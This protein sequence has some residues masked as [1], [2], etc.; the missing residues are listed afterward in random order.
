MQSTG[1]FGIGIHS[2]F[3]VTDKVYFKTKCVGDT[4]FKDL[5]IHSS[6]NLGW[7]EY[8]ERNNAKEYPRTKSGTKCFIAFDK[9]ELSDDVFL[10]NLEYYELEDVFGV[11][12]DIIL[13]NL[14]NSFKFDMFKLIIR[15]NTE[16]R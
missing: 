5:I 2:A 4:C 7:V 15:I 1:A 12:I 13:I 16:E 6:K 10:S 11:V 8:I 14:Y 9:N 3:M